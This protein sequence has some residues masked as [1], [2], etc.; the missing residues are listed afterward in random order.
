[1]G[2]LNFRQEVAALSEEHEIKTSLWKGTIKDII[3]HFPPGANA[4]VEVR[5]FHGSTQ[6]LPE[7]GGVALDDATPIFGVERPINLGDHIRVEWA[8][9]DDTYEHTISVIVNIE[10]R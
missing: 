10:G 3:V 4:L 8:N 2:Q 7:K 6:I 5:V 9:H 1:M